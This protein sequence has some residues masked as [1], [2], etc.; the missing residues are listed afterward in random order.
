MTP[1]LAVTSPS[2]SRQ[3]VLAA[4][5]CRRYPAARLNTAGTRLDGA[6]LAASRRVSVDWTPGKTA[7]V[8]EADLIEQSGNVDSIA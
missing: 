2:F 4:E 5:T 3:P 6:A 1:S 7:G 8:G